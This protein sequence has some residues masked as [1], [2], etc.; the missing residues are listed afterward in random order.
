M[1]TKVLVVDD[2]A[3]M[4]RRI[5]DLLTAAGFA[6]ETA[7]DGADALARLRSFDPDVV[8]LDVTMPG[9]DGL[10]C[11]RRI[12]VEH[13]K[14]VVMVSSLT[15]EGA[16]VT[17]EAMRLGAVEAVQKPS[18]AGTIGRIAADL[19]ETV[20]AAAFSR[21]RRV[22]GLRERLRLVRARI[23][24]EDFLAAP[25]ETS[26][27]AP[28]AQ[29]GSPQPGPPQS[30]LVLIGVSTGGPGTL[31]DILP[32]LPANF[33][34]PVVVAQHMPATFTGTLARRLDEICA[35]RVAEAAQPAPVLPGTVLIARGGGD[36]MVVRRGGRLV[37]QPVPAMAERSWHPNVDRLVESALPIVPAPNLIG[38]LLTGMG[39]DG[40]AAMAELHRR[41]GRT[42]AEAEESAVVFGMPQ[43]LIRRGG[44][45]LV[46]PADRI[47][48]QL[49]RWALPAGARL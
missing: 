15:A 6:V 11:L 3:L 30:G 13:P 14:P 32:A 12:M 41:G 27:G 21:P 26:P 47:A 38:V 2:S 18:G 23:A 24:G 10:D 34:W 22:Q 37:L 31:E 43:E 4:R 45:E 1:A 8:T 29:P 49:V 5:A 35:L 42:I 7:V 16:D 25:P 19:V 46:L 39:H 9:M 44:A 20:R 36:A 33:P 40:A 17:L 48:Q 28:A